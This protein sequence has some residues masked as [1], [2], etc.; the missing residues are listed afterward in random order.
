MRRA[1]NARH[2]LLL[3]GAL[4]S[5]IGHTSEVTQY[6]RDTAGDREA[7]VDE[8]MLSGTPASELEL[9]ELHGIIENAFRVLV[10][11]PNS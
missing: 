4:M 11:L 3:E 6:L 7:G 5:A 10:D 2:Q 8:L 1:L 9:R